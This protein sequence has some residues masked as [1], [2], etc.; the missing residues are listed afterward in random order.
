MLGHVE[1]LTKHVLSDSFENTFAVENKEGMQGRF[2]YGC[3][4]VLFG[5]FLRVP[6]ASFFVCLLIVPLVPLV[7]EARDS[8]ASALMCCGCLRVFLRVHLHTCLSI[9]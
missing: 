3:K 8:A 7:I 6:L 1:P 5:L 4:A 2:A 9:C